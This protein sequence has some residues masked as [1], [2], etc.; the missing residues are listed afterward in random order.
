MFSN[1]KSSFIIYYGMEKWKKL[2][3]INVVNLFFRLSAFGKLPNKDSRHGI[4][5]LVGRGAVGIW[6]WAAG[7]SGQP[8]RNCYSVAMLRF[9][10]GRYY[11]ENDSKTT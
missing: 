2:S 10:G 5:R 11:G 4:K 6:R 9:Y 1:R 7:A 8:C 3:G